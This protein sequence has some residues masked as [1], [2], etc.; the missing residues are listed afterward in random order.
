M[1]TEEPHRKQAGVLLAGLRFLFL[2]NWALL[3]VALELDVLAHAV[4]TDPSLP[5]K[6]ANFGQPEG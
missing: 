6:L 3:V 1:F 2:H 4:D 5:C